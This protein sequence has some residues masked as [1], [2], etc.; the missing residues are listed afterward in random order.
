MN[1]ATINIHIRQ[2]ALTKSDAFI[3]FRKIFLL[4][5]VKASDI[6]KKI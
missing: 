4:F 3:I 1:F 6:L 5:I 2:F